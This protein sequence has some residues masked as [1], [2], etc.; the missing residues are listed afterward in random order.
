MK[1]RR[2]KHDLKRVQLMDRREKPV[3]YEVNEISDQDILKARGSKYGP[4]QPMWETIGIKQWQNF[5]F[6][7][8]KCGK[9][10]RPPTDGELAHLACMNM[11]EVKT[12]RALHDPIEE[13]H[14]LD[15][16][17]YFTIADKVIHGTK[18]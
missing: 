17:N 14:S 16:R 1:E 10:M 13:D 6:L 15:G 12:V 8:N 4:M 3:T 5:V 9:E 7:N 11:I 2:V 18:D